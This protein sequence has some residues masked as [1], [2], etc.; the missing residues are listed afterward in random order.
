VAVVVEEECGETGEPSLLLGAPLEANVCLVVVYTRAQWPLA[1][2]QHRCASRIPFLLA[3][4]SLASSLPAAIPRP[5]GGAEEEAEECVE[6][7]GG[8]GGGAVA[9]GGAVVVLGGGGG[10]GTW[11]GPVATHAPGLLRDLL[12][13]AS[14]ERALAW[15]ASG[16]AVADAF[17][18]DDGAHASGAV[19]AA[20]AQ[21]PAGRVAGGGGGGV[22]ARLL[23]RCMRLP[24]LHRGMRVRFEVV[25]QSYFAPGATGLTP[26]TSDVLSSDEIRAAVPLTPPRPGVVPRSVRL[27]VE[28]ARHW[29][30]AHRPLVTGFRIDAGDWHPQKALVLETASYPAAAA[31]T[32]RNPASASRCVPAP[33]CQAIRAMPCSAKPCSAPP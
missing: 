33:Q 16:C 9:R 23:L 32:L 12:G 14:S 24:L 1:R 19:A 27:V 25:A 17:Y 5:T 22:C 21:T 26:P 20:A 29:R 31:A 30:K 8:E 7:G 6:G 15:L 28:G 13:G 18:A 11:H 3:R 10:G 2:P 4:P